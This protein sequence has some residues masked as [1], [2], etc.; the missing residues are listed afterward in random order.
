VRML[1]SAAEEGIGVTSFG[2]GIDFGAD[3][4]NQVSQVRGGNYFHLETPDKIRRVFDRDFDLM[5]TP[6]AYDLQISLMAPAG[7]EIVDAY[8]LAGAGTT[9]CGELPSSR[10]IGLTVPTVFLSRGGGGMFMRLKIKPGDDQPG[11]PVF[12]GHVLYNDEA[13]EPVEQDSA[14][15]LAPDVVPNTTETEP[16]IRMAAQLINVIDVL[17][18]FASRSTDETLVWSV[19]DSL[20]SEVAEL[21]A[22]GDSLLNELVLLYQAIEVVR[23]Q[24]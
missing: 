1:E 2:V 10:C 20:R 21:G 5:V 11:D 13:G 6:L 18:E 8:G 9:R 3:L 14:V 15:S 24:R 23:E 22:R 16:S 12:V 4:A 19:V 17:K 7:Y